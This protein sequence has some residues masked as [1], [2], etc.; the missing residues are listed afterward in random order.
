VECLKVVA[1][2][3]AP[4]INK[5]LAF[6]RLCIVIVPRLVVLTNS[7]RIN[8]WQSAHVSSIRFYALAFALLQSVEAIRVSIATP[9][10]ILDTPSV[11]H[12]KSPLHLI[13]VTS[14]FWLW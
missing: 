4:R 8:K 11:F 13:V 14:A 12:A 7:R 10:P 6:E 1:I 9:V 3:Q 5:P 2:S